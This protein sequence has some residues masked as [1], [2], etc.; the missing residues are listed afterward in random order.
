MVATARGVPAMLSSCCSTRAPRLLMA[1]WISCCSR[2]KETWSACRAEVSTATTTQTIATATMTPIGT[3]K[4]TRACFH[5]DPLVSPAMRSCAE[6]GTLHPSD[7][8][9]RLDPS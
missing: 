5:R 1:C 8:L 2:L 9:V 4:L 3:T 7:I 6:T